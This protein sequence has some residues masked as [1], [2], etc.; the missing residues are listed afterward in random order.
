M[1]KFRAWECPCSVKLSHIWVLSLSKFEMGLCLC[2]RMSSKCSTSTCGWGGTMWFWIWPIVDSHL[3]LAIPRRP[4]GRCWST[5]VGK[6]VLKRQ[7]IQPH[8]FVLSRGS[9]IPGVGIEMNRCFDLHTSFSSLLSS[10]EQRL[11]TCCDLLFS[12]S[13]A[14]CASAWSVCVYFLSREENI[15]FVEI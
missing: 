1:Q 2:G 6:V 5:F 10:W 14:V 13:L 11:Y 3:F 15:S 12:D 7:R 4:T 8:I 9:Y